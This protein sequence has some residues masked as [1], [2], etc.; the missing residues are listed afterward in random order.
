MININIYEAKAKLSYYVAQALK[1]KRVIISK[2]NIPLVEII[3]LAKVK[4]RRVIGQSEVKF[5]VPKSFFEPLP[6]ELTKAF[7]N[8]E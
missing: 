2:R 6:G 4:S 3:P 5:T 8:P 7:N 1:G